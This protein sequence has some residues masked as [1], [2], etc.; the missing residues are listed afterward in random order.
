[1]HNRLQF[2]PNPASHTIYCKVDDLHEEAWVDIYDVSGRLL[3]R[4][5]IGPLR[6]DVGVSDIPPGIYT[7][8]VSTADKVYAAPLL[9][10]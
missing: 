6:S 10:K 4:S 2:Y 1:M 8:V 9:V 5:T 3:R 7:V